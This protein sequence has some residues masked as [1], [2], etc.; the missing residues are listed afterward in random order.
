MGKERISRSSEGMPMAAPDLP[1]SRFNEKNVNKSDR[2][3]NIGDEIN[4]LKVKD[5]VFRKRC[6]L[7]FF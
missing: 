2:K 6:H 4:F 5:D 7:C 1:A 3:K